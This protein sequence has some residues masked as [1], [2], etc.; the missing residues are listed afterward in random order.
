[1]YIELELT[2]ELKGDI[3]KVGSSTVVHNFSVWIGKKDITNELSEV[4]FD[5]ALEQFK[6][7]EGF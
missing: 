2:V 4:E 3:E 1:M 5:Q 6:K 7:D